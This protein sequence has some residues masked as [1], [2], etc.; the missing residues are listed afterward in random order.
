MVRLGAALALHLNLC[1][2]AGAPHCQGCAHNLTWQWP[3]ARWAYFLQLPCRSGTLC[4][5]NAGA[6]RLPGTLPAIV[7]LAKPAGSEVMPSRRPDG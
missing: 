3:A 4:V 5:P 7:K 6:S 1:T 2:S